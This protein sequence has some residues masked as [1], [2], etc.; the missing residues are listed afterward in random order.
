MPRFVHQLWY[1]KA[2][3]YYLLIPFSVIYRSITFVRRLFLTHR[4]SKFLVPV[5]VVGNITVGGVGKTPLVIALCQEFMR[6]QLSV[7]IVSRGYKSMIANYPHEVKI[8]DSAL[9]VGDE[10]FMMLHRTGC[11][12]VISPKRVEAID[13]LLAKHDVDVIISDDGLQHYAMGR[14]IE[15]AVIDGVRR[16]GN[17]HCLPAGPLREPVKRLNSVDFIVNN[18]SEAQNGE[19][20][21]TAKVDGIYQLLTDK[22][23]DESLKNKSFHAIAGIGNPD[24]YFSTIDELGI[25]YKP[26]IF[27]DH[28][29]YQQSDFNFNHDL[30]IMTEKDAVKCR[31]FAT[32]SMYYVKISAILEPDFFTLLMDKLSCLK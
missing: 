8:D 31:S 17:G 7:G 30:I 16:L 3:W 15:V 13:Y 1:G 29:R 20:L 5:V 4:Q 12:V 25:R 23:I 24:R 32:D 18:G 14:D 2:K 10:P 22:P 26:R 11:A 28:H 6:N 9:D 19:Y 27:S 21:M